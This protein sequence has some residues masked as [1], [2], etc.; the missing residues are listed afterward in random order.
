MFCEVHD[1]RLSPWMNQRSFAVNIEKRT[2]DSTCFFCDN[3]SP[4]DTDEMCV[5]FSS[6][7]KNARLLFSPA[8]RPVE[9]FEAI[10]GAAD[11][12]VVAA[13]GG[14]GRAGVARER[15]GSAVAQHVPEV[16]GVE[17]RLK[18]LGGGRTRF[19]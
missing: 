17:R 3:R 4:P 10:V 14:C 6:P 13:G 9:G 15:I 7:L 19:G 12:E 5:V 2:P 18:Q 8:L 16:A 1:S 11:E